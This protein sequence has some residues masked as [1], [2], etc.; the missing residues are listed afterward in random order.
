MALASVTFNGTRLNDSDSNTGWGNYNSGGGAP[1]SESANAYQV[2][3]GSASNVGVV[4][5]KVNST[6]AR[7]GVDYNGTAVDYT[8]AA[9]RLLFLKVYVSDA[10]DLNTTFGLEVSIG[11]ADTSNYHTYNIAGSGANLD[12]YSEYPPQGG[13]LITAI[14]PTIDTWADSIDNGGAFDQT[15]VSWYAVG[16]QFI[17][18]FAKAENVA[19]DAIDYGT[20]LTITGGTGADPAATFR[21]FI[22]FDQDV[23]NNRYGVVVGRGFSLRVNGILT[24][25]AGADT[26]FEDSQSIVTFNDGYHSAGLFGITCDLS[27]A[28]NSFIINST[29]I[30]NGSRNNSSALDTRPDFIVTGTSGTLSSSANLRN[31]RNITYTSACTIDGA[32]IECQ[33]LTQ[34]SA[35]ISNSV[36]RTRSLPNEAC[37]QDPTFNSTTGLN[38][39]EFINPDSTSGHAIEID[40]VGTYDLTNIKF[41]DYG[42]DQTYNSAIFVSATTGTVNININGGDT[43]TVYTAG[44]TVNV[45]NTVTVSIDVIDIEDNSDIQGA[46]VYIVAA[47]GGDLTAGTVILSGL[48]DI[49][50]NAANS[51]FSYTNP[52]PITGVVRKSSASPYYKEGKVVGTITAAGFSATIPMSKD[53]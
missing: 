44:A 39:T 11:S 7:L 33:L 4:G 42:A 24:I 37:L 20:G 25:G 2:S 22:A 12:V 35:D 43:P 19:F 32:D 5:K 41:T 13:Y 31:H 40:T 23:R 16:A 9:N 36:I 17:N 48:T 15:S 18:G 3:T 27:R 38:N 52:Q 6:S 49:N 21:D 46:R 10:F 45:S 1:S 14:D 28:N 30:G 50:G 53:E 8:N 29:V 34:S 26:V 47:A 51:G